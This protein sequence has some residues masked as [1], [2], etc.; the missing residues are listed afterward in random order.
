MAFD[1]TPVARNIG[2]ARVESFIV[3]DLCGLL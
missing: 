3:V 1:R 2:R